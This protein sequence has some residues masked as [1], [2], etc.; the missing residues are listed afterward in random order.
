MAIPLL[1]AANLLDRD[2]ADVEA[3][4]HE[5][6]TAYGAFLRRSL[7]CRSPASLGVMAEEIV[8]DACFLLWRT[9]LRER[10]RTPSATAPW[11][12]VVTAIEAVRGARA[13]RARQGAGLP[14]DD[15]PTSRCSGA[16]SYPGREHAA[17]SAAEARQPVASADDL[18]PRIRAQIAALPVGR[19]QAVALHVRGFTSVEIG[20]LLGETAAQ[21]RALLCHGLQDL[22]L[23]LRADRLTASGRC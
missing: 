8:Q 1:T 10:H 11:R 4:V 13:Q 15:D 14:D 21:A 18:S 6:L 7:T 20:W 16:P 22:R 17:P 3:E 23:R 5:Q 12:V 19:R 9:M 2:R